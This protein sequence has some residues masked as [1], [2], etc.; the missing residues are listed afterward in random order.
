M[1]SPI[2]SG[3]VRTPSGLTLAV[4][5]SRAATL[6][7]PSDLTSV[8]TA[9]ET[10]TVNGRAY[11][12]TYDSATSGVTERSPAGRDAVRI[13]DAKGHVIEER[14]PGFIPI[15]YSYD[16]LGQLI[17]KAQGDRTT[18]YSFN[19]AG[20][21]ESETDALSRTRRFEYDAV[22]RITKETLPD[23]RE[24]LL[25]YDANGN[26]TSI[27][28]PARPAHN[29]S[30]TPVDLESE[31]A[32]PAVVTP[33]ATTYSY[34]LDRQLTRVTRPDGQVIDV[35]YDTGGRLTSV[36][37][38]RGTVSYTYDTAGR[39]ASATAPASA[40]ATASVSPEVVAFAYDG[41]LL[42]SASA[43]G[44][45]PGVVA[46]SYDNDFRVTSVSVNGAAVNF[47]YDADSL[48][49][50]A[51]ALTISRDAQNRSTTVG[52]IATSYTYDSYGDLASIAAPNFSV[53]HT[54]DSLGRI[55]RKSETVNGAA[56]TL[57]YAYDSAGRLASGGGGM[58]TY[59][60]NGNRLPGVYDDQDRL[61]SF[62]TATYTYNANGDLSSKTNPTGTTSYT[63]DA[64]GNL[65]SAVLP[66]ATRIDYAIDALNRRI[67]KRV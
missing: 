32:P 34:N 62:G 64:L 28:P 52:S 14:L 39:T 46:Y 8:A 24:L 49:T 45:A 31:Y 9:T 2:A 6:I 17:S 15:A 51:G 43:T 65:T 30:Y 20:R 36:T 13:L 37:Q 57:D 41:F 22:G 40:T 47:A 58:Y 55:T 18:T 67:A 19:A 3:S 59:D 53:T 12:R 63:Y 4:S 11:Q 21:I 35:G 23:Q 1:Q 38:P 16:V 27:T 60:G 7:D 50:D 42:T 56:A 25:S 10:M 29:F 61:L 26:A 66:D 44:S 54:R 48:L 5:T 33:S